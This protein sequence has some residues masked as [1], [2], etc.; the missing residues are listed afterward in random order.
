MSSTPRVR[1][2]CLLPVSLVLL[3]VACST[4]GALQSER[5]AGYHG[6]VITAEQMEK[7]G[8][9]NAWELLKRFA[10]SFTFAE[11]SQGQPTRIYIRGRSSILLRED[12]LVVL[13]GVEISDIRALG[14]IPARQLHRIRILSG[15]DSSTSYGTRAANGAIILETRQGVTPNSND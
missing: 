1:A 8:L 13:D 12:P 2:P 3:M 5:D 10:S 7:S 4:S 6:R 11:N 14:T 9:P 15:G